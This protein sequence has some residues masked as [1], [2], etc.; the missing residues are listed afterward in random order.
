MMIIFY[1][2]IG[3]LASTIGAIT[4][5]GGGIFVKPLLD[6]FG[7]YPVATIGILSS[8]S[9]FSMSAV[10]L[11]T[12]RREVKVMD[13]EKAFLIAGGAVL[14]GIIGNRIFASLLAYD[15]VGAIQTSFLIVIFTAIL[16]YVNFKDKIPQ[17]HVKDKRIMLGMGLLLGLMS[18]FLD[19]G[20]GPYIVSLMSLFFA[21]HAKK[22]GLY[23]IFIIF[24]AQ[25]SSLLLTTVSGDIFDHNLV[26]LPGMVIGGIL[27]GA[28]GSNLS[29]WFSI[30][31]VEVIF[32]IVIAALLLLN[33]YNLWVYL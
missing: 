16:I 10:S 8:T 13:K 3:L 28:L 19:I 11:W 25:L 29:K 30:E 12:R 27:G 20:G 4:G 26:M 1:F 33:I 17:Y 24:F 14:G 23:S 31:R 9:V 22:A 7:H 6:F 21:M 2:L 15:W 18:A 5:V 32:K